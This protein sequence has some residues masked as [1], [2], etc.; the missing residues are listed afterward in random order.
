MSNRITNAF[1]EMQP[2]TPMTEDETEFFIN[3]YVSD[4]DNFKIDI[5]NID[6]EGETFKNFKPVINSFL[7]QVLLKRLEVNTSI[8]MSL[9][10][11]L[12]LL[13][14]INNLAESVMY[15]YYL[16]I[17][18]PAGTLFNIKLLTEIFPLGFYSPEQLNGIWDVQKKIPSDGLSGIMD[19]LLDFEK[20]WLE[21]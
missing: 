18:L 13:H 3:I 11:L 9:G 4:D 1:N 14:H 8:K 6:K 21:I 16:H 10:G 17:M 5:N 2:S 7:S 12:M 19:N 15:A 20:T